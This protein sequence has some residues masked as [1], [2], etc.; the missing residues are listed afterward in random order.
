MPDTPVVEPGAAHRVEVG[1]K[2]GTRD[3]AGEN[4]KGRVLEDLEIALD[5]V[6]VIDVY[7]ILADLST[8]ELDRVRIELF[9]DLIIQESTASGALAKDFDYLIEVGFRPGVTD[10]VGKSSAEGIADVR[11]FF[12]NLVLLKFD[13]H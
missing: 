5:D 4:V 8:E 7:T 3:A 6:R 9:T 1:V 10:N 2:A 12:R 11:V 13:C